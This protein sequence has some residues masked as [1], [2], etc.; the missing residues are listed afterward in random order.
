MSE[1]T[2]EVASDEPVRTTLDV[3]TDPKTRKAAR[4]VLATMKA[5]GHL[6]STSGDPSLVRMNIF[7]T[8]MAEAGYEIDELTMTR[9][10]ERFVGLH[11]PPTHD[12]ETGNKL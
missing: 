3:K 4:T 2:P 7:R 9:L 5:D 1:P 10:W 12:Y 6:P 8:R 11:L